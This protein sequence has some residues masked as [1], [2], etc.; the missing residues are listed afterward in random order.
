MCFKD[1]A[2]LRLN[3]P[4]INCTLVLYCDILVFQQSMYGQILPIHELPRDPWKI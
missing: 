3:H 2:T 1:I 4:R